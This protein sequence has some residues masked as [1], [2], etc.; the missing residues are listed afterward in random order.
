MSRAQYRRELRAPVRGF[1]SGVFDYSQFLNA[2]GSAIDQGVTRAWFNGAAQCSIQPDELDIRE[3][4]ALQAFII[5]QKM[6]LGKFADAIET[7][8]RASGSK[9]SPLYHRLELWVNRYDEAFS[10]S[11]GMACA[12][13]KAIWAFGPTREHCRSCATFVGRVYRR[14]VWRDNGAMPQSRNLCCGGLRCRC[15]LEP[16]SQRITPGRFPVSALCK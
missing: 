9:L 10:K 11:A 3:L 16:T 7:G 8:S 4:R 1:W 15:R 5:T 12:N 6:F 2:F 13:Q 14:W